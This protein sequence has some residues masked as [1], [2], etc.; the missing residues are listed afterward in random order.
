MRFFEKIAAKHFIVQIPFEPPTILFNPVPTSSF[1]S[2]SQKKRCNLI[3][4]R[5]ETIRA[6]DLASDA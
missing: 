3:A 1:I 5:E 6:Y 4:E 2:L